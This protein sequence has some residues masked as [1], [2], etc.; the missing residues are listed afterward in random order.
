MFTDRTLKYLQVT[1]DKFVADGGGLYVRVTVTGKKTFVYR[2]Q[3]GGTSRWRVLGHYPTMSL[4]QARN[5]AAQMAT[6]GFV[7]HTV[8]E[9]YTEYLPTLRR[10]YDEPE[11]VESRFKRDILP[12]LG[13]RRLLDV[14]RAAVSEVLQKIVDRGSPVAAN[15][16]LPDL[17]HFFAWCVERGWLEKD[18]ALGITRKSVGG[19]ERGKRRTLSFEELQRFIPELRGTRLALKTRLALALILLTGQRPSEVLEFHVAQLQPGG[20][21]WFVPAAHTKTK[22]ADQKVYLSSL[23]R[24]L[25]KLAI[26]QFGKRPFGF[27]H[28]TL[29]QAVRRLKWDPPF[30]PHDL[31]RTM[32]TRLADLGV[33]PHVV[34]KMLN[35]KMEGVM[36]V[37][38][39]AEYLPER[40]AA[41]RLWGAKLAQLRRHREAHHPDRGVPGAVDPSAADSRPARATDP[42]RDQRVDLPPVD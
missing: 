32:S 37:Y 4:L 1:K 27:H 41:W 34:E 21:W 17:K 26:Q 7:L 19:R 36:A 20:Y 23:A 35:H 13:A 33:A 5:R 2:T 10:A 31:R 6:K 28:T 8:A 25:L 11:Q 16:T 42:V 22:D 29:S 15:R 3:V 14:D 40:R 9:A 30:T 18:P 12:Q 24:H 39:R 38:N